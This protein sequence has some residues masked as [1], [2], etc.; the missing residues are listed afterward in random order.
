MNSGRGSRLARA[1]ILCQ[2]GGPHGVYLNLVEG[3][4]WVPDVVGSNPIT[5]TVLLLLEDLFWLVAPRKSIP[6][7]LY[8]V[9]RAAAGIEWLG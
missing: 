6:A 7:A 2:K 3:R 9:P 8:P 5:P 4:L 1:G